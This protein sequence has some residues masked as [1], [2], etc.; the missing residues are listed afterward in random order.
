MCGKV[1]WYIKIVR[2]NGLIHEDKCGYNGLNHMILCVTETYC[3]RLNKNY[4]S[5]TTKELK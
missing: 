5:I 1:G 3:K 2:Y 4:Y